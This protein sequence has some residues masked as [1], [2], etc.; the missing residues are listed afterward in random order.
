MVQGQPGHQGVQL[1]AGQRRLQPQDRLPG[2]FQRPVPVGGMGVGPVDLGQHG[3]LLPDCLLMVLPCL[4][5]GVPGRAQHK[6]GEQ[7]RAAQPARQGQQP[8]VLR[9][10]AGLQPHSA[11]SPS[12]A[13]ST[14][15]SRS[16]YP[17]VTDSYPV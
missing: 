7:R 12:G 4:A 16:A 3:L 2:V 5:V 9:G 6:A 11:A 1:V 17:P 15:L 8:P 10:D 14:Q 13:A